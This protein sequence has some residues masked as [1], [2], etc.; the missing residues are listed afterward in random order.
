MNRPEV[1]YEDLDA[2]RVGLLACLLREKWPAIRKLTDAEWEALPAPVRD[3]VAS[4]GNE[5]LTALA[6]HENAIEWARVVAEFE[7]VKSSAQQVV[8][9]RLAALADPIHAANGRKPKTIVS[10]RT[11]AVRR[12]YGFDLKALADVASARHP[13]S[14]TGDT[15]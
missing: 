11:G 9:D 1:I 2:S 8:L 6:P 5:C 14:R 12:D 15:T 4:F 7:R 10:G 13:S 3:V